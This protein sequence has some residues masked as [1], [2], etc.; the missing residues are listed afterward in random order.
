[1]SVPVALDDFPIVD[2]HCHGWR[3]ERKLSLD[4][5]GFLDRITLTQDRRMA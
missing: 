2:A 3:N 5:N 1:M 4:P